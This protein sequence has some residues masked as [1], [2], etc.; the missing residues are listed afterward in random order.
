[1]VQWLRDRDDNRL[2]KIAAA[3]RRYVDKEKEIVR[4]YT[5]ERMGLRA[6]S[7]YF[8][9]RPSIPGVRKILIQ[10]AVYRSEER[11]DQ[12]QARSQERRQAV[13]AREKL[14]RH[15]L[16]VCLSNLRRGVGVEPHV[17]R[18]AGTL[19]HLRGQRHRAKPSQNATPIQ[20]TTI[21]YHCE[22]QAHR[23]LVCRASSPQR[24]FA[25]KRGTAASRRQGT[26]K[27]CRGNCTI[28]ADKIAER[29]ELAS[30]LPL[31]DGADDDLS[32]LF[33]APFAGQCRR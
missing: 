11:L 21:P 1:M 6:I 31:P 12:Q 9:R 19:D 10:W 29:N 8:N 27:I 16:A 30:V 18:K 17:K 7:R 23:I 13:I 5:D 24:I 14:T 4:M 20:T 32:P 28:G 15:R 3:N 2:A 33:R 26:P 25:E 22:R